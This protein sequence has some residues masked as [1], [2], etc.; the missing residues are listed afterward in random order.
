MA[1]PK[2][3]Q[4]HLKEIEALEAQMRNDGEAPAE[5]TDP[6]A[7]IAEVV[8]PAAE[9]KQPE[10]RVVEAEPPT[11][12]EQADDAPK[13]QSE[14]E[15]QVEADDG[16]WEDRY[17]HLNGKYQKEV[18]RLY[19]EI[20]ELRST[21]AQMQEEQQRLAA[22]RP[23]EPE[24][25]AQPEAPAAL[26][27]D[28]DVDAFGEDLIDLQRRVAREVAAE[29]RSELDKLRQENEQL[30]GQVSSVQ[31]NTFETRLLQAVPDFVQINNDPAWIE[32]LNEVDPMLRA[33]RRTVA[34]AAFERGDVEG[35]KHYVDMFRRLSQPAAKPD[36]QAELERQVQPT[37]TAKQTAPATAQPKM[38]T[39]A[40][41]GAAF[42]RVQKL[43]A[44]GKYAEASA[45]ESE[46]SAAYVEGRVSG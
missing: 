4:Q 41:A 15:A 25:P 21:I 11:P 18:P 7:P 22:A 20:K 45:L 38:Y 42:D 34:Q 33:P 35:V 40:E 46:I 13:D 43:V 2:Q 32:W 16:K 31:S 3:V 23:P 36:R 44:Q 28:M 17:K 14:P 27:T 39:A 6:T 12:V 8:K 37:R 30:K 24:T 29:F 1:L 9:M 5:Q 10:L 19:N 26:V